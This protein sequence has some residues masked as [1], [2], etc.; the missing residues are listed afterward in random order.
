MQDNV[1]YILYFAKNDFK[2]TKLIEWN[3]TSP[4][5]NSVKNMW[6][7]LKKRCI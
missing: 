6:F 2:D 5:I 1:S 7:I 3:P 4:D